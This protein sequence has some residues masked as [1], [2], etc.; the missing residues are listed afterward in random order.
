MLPSVPTDTPWPQRHRR[1]TARLSDTRTHRQVGR[2][3]RGHGDAISGVAFSPD[4]HTLTTTPGDEPSSSGHTYAQ[5]AR[6]A[7][8]RPPP[9]QH[10]S[11]VSAPTDA[12]WP[13]STPTA[14]SCGYVMPHTQKAPPAQGLASDSIAYSPD[15]RTLTIGGSSRCACWTRAP[16]NHSASPSA[17]APSSRASPSVPTGAISPL[18]TLMAPSDCGKAFTRLRFD[19]LKEQVCGL[20]IGNFTKSEWQELTGGLAYPTTF[21]C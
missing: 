21:A 17:Q 20:S 10:T 5:A 13:P 6:P 14:S 12:H 18:P 2:S 8:P 9:G 15:G 7:Q 4:S 16:S 3:L 11:V 19:D 1:R